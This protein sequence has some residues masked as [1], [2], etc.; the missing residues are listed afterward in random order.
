[1]RAT[2]S[3]RNESYIIFT[4][5]SVTKGF[6][7]E[8]TEVYLVVRIRFAFFT[9][10]RLIP[11]ACNQET[12]CASAPP[13]YFRIGE[14]GF[15]HPLWW[16]WKCLPSLPQFNISYSLVKKSDDGHIFLHHQ[17]GVDSLESYFS[18]DLL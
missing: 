16:Q 8:G 5:E 14:G 7:P 17:R 15:L 2:H 12:V 4:L 9:I 13:N 10:V 3:S 6:V 18:K 11:Q 1:M